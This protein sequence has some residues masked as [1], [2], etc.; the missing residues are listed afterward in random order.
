MQPPLAVLEKMI[1]LRL[2]IDAADESNACLKVIPG[3]H[4]YGVIQQPDISRIVSTDPVFYCRVAA[5]D[6]V[7]MRPHL[8][9]ASGKAAYP[10]HRRVVHLEYSSYPLP[11]GVN[12][13]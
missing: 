4:K 5:G 9:H 2:H 3:S 11:V 10:T 6:A 12:W 8:L 13:S 1:T 7:V